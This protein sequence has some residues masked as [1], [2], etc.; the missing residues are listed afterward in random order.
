MSF[1]KEHYNYTEI[2]KNENKHISHKQIIE[3]IDK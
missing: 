3:S 2:K 1:A